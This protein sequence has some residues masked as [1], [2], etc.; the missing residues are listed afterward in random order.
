MN[1]MSVGSQFDSLAI[2]Y[3]AD[4]YEAWSL[5]QIIG[6]VR[7]NGIELLK[8]GSMAALIARRE[9]GGMLVAASKLMTSTIEQ[10]ILFRRLA[11]GYSV[12]RRHMKLWVFWERIETMLRDREVSYRRRGLPFVVP[13]Y[14]RC[15]ELA[16]LLRNSSPPPYEPPPPPLERGPL[17]DDMAVLREMVEDLEQKNRLERE[18]N[19][20]LLVELDIARD[21]I[22]DLARKSPADEQTTGFIGKI[23]GWFRR[24]RPVPAPIPPD[25]PSEI[26]VRTG[27]CLDLIETEPNVYHAVATDAPYSIGLHGK[28]W[29]STDVSFSPILWQRLFY[30]LRPGGYI[31]FF[32]APRLYHRAAQAAEKCRL[33]HL[34]VSRMALPRRSAQADQPV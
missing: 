31:A 11:M 5:A 23:A 26:E 12:G 22:R 2:G 28:E 14:R 15:L 10:T 30:V 1:E 21:E 17:P 32:T 24:R 27:D 8:R 29:D 6:A 16:G 19:A 33:H 13:G 7:G 9:I 34:A 25:R 4:R 3:D 20:R 18:S